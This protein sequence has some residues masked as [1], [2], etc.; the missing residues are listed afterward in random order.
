MERLRQICCR[1]RSF[2]PAPP[3]E[4]LMGQPDA[5]IRLALTPIRFAELLAGV[6]GIMG[7][8]LAEFAFAGPGGNAEMGERCIDNPRRFRE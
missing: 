8:N 7:Q 6:L 2:Y 3:F 5:V 1:G 4:N